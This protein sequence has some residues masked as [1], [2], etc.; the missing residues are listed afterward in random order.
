VAARK[1]RPVLYEVARR[2]RV[3]E[4][5]WKRRPEPPPPEASP[6]PSSST[7]APEGGP[8]AES[9]RPAPLVRVVGERV[10]L[11]LGWP[12]V[13]VILAAFV[14]VLGVSFHAGT[15]YGQS[16]VTPTGDQQ[17][18]APADQAGGAQPQVAL[19]S[20]A[21][22]PD[23][24]GAARPQAP[25]AAAGANTL[26][27]QPRRAAPPP[28]QPAPVKL[29]DGYHYVFIQFFRK[30][31]MK[32]A[33]AAAAFLQAN[34]LPCTIQTAPDDIRLIATE[35]FR[36]DEGDTAAR[37]REKQRCEELKRR[38]KELGKEYARAGGGYAFDQCLERKISE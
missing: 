16:T 36:L 21:G 2:D 20:P 13:A 8:Q 15:R 10:Q 38:I 22:S 35:P 26:A 14:V 12:G 9:G 11:T 30:T 24:A 18:S 28:E 27:G 4:S 3:R 6:A 17:P 19:G 29:Q 7:P 1:T 23:G 37:Q 31:R 5:D 25:P 33:Q 32:D 34:G